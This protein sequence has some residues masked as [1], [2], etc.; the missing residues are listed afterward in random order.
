MF[1]DKSIMYITDDDYGLI[2]VYEVDWLP[3]AIKFELVTTIGEIYKPSVRNNN[4][5]K[6]VDW[7]SNRILSI[8]RRYS[9][10]ILKSA[11]YSYSDAIN[12]KVKIALA[13]RAVSIN[14]CY[15][16]K[17]DNESI[18]WSSVDIKS[19]NLS[20]VVVDVALMGKNLSISSRE[21]LYPEITTFGV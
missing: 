14:D 17:F 21:L 13:C 1:K 15:W 5:D 11:R 20:S 2:E 10:V 19:N 3:F 9:K 7:L 12:N 16:I 8:N 6:I 4:R 18:N